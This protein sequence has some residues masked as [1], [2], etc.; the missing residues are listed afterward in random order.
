MDTLYA[1]QH[2][3]SFSVFPLMCYSTDCSVFRTLFARSTLSFSSRSVQRVNT[4]LLATF[5]PNVKHKCEPKNVSFSL[6]G[7]KLLFHI[8]VIQTNIY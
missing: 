8:D 7:L 1:V 6:S 5:T 3:N 4:V 2:R